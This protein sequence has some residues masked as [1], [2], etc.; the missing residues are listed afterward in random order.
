[1]Q[2]LCMRIGAQFQPSY[3]TSMYVFLTVAYWL[4][5]YGYLASAHVGNC[6]NP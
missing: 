6:A 5:V 4:Y 2:A 3:V 1:M